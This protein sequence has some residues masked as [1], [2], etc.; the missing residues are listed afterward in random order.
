M[1]FFSPCAIF[2]YLFQLMLLVG[3]I[4]IF[5]CIIFIPFIYY[6]YYYYHVQLL[7]LLMLIYFNLPCFCV[8]VLNLNIQQIYFSKQ[9]K[10]FVHN[11]CSCII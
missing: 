7:S 11:L 1:S 10:T 2:Y 6:C 8:C 5:W 3:V 9:L 4:L